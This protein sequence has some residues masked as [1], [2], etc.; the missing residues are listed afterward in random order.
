MRIHE[1]A[2]S[3]NIDSKEL[4]EKLKAINFPVK[5]HMSTVDEETAEIIRHEIEDLKKK[6]IESNVVEVEF[7][8][9]VKD[10]A[11]KLNQKSSDI[12]KFLLQ[13]GKFYTINQNID[14]DLARQIAYHYKVNLKR[15]PS[16]EEEIFSLKIDEKEKEKRAPVVTL[17]GH[18]DHGKTS[19]LDYIR[20][21]KIAEQETGGITQHI[22]AYRV[23]LPKGSITFLDTPGHETFT[24]MRARG[25]DIT[26]IVILVVAADEG[27]KPQTVEA[28]DHARQAKVPIIV[29]INKIDKE[30]ANIDLVKQQLSKYGLVPEDWGGNTI[31]VGVSAKTGKGMDDLLDM[32]LLQAELMDLKASYKAPLIGVVIEAKLSKGRGPLATVLVQ[33]G[34]LKKGDMCVCGLYWGKIRALYDDR[35]RLIEEALPSYPV[36]VIGLNGVPNPADKIF[37]VPDEKMARQIVEKKKEEEKLK[38]RKTT[39]HLKLEDLYKRKQEGQKQLRIVLKADVGGSLEAIEEAL[40]KLS[41]SEVEV[42]FIHLGV[43]A[44]SF[45]DV[46]LAEV[47][48]AVIVG[49]RVETDGQAKEAAKTKGIEIRVYHIIYELIDDIKSAMEGLLAP[50]VRKVFLGRAKVKK[51]FKLSK[52]IVVAGCVVEKGKILRTGFVQLIRDNQQIFE[53]KITSLKRFKDD[54]REVNEGLECG[55]SIGYADI[56]EGDYIDVFSEEVITRKLGD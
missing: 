28:I 56:K 7:P 15:K 23:V 5:S 26:D 36:E 33:Q 2:K 13:Q 10:L 20:K 1:L 11:V 24:A 35:G 18:I 4:I 21:S 45:S 29:A 22:G 34:I 9:S 48:D 38:E 39:V 46:L 55:I 37:V 53:G 40:K 12:L 42:Q 16:Y 31:T 41:T 54:V 30:N 43:G 19:I 51:V 6:E 8:I 32:I 50:Q 14:E 25:A 17:M 3:L 27:I 44:I 52:D 47:S 49:F